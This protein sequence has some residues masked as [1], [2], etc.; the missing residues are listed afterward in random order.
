MLVKKFL[1]I[2]L[3]FYALAFTPAAYASSYGGVFELPSFVPTYV[4]SSGY[5]VPASST[6]DFGQITGSS[7]KTIKVLKIYMSYTATAADLQNVFVIKRSSADSGGTLTSGVPVP[8]NSSSPAASASVCTYTANPTVGT[9]VG[10]IDAVTVLATNTGGAAVG[11]GRVLIFDADKYG[12]ACELHGTSEALCVNGGGNS[13][14]SHSPM[15]QL[16]YVWTEQ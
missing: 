5:F 12:D 15:V 11:Q 16:T 2:L 4:A 7:S 6:T 10:Q 13:F 8:L 1:A 14:S 3:A 9:A